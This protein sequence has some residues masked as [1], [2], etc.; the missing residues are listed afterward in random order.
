MVTPKAVQ[1][2]LFH[3]LPHPNVVRAPA[4]DEC[5]GSTWRL[6]LWD[7]IPAFDAWSCAYTAASILI[8][9]QA[10]LLDDDLLVLDRKVRLPTVHVPTILTTYTIL[11]S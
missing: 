8:Q 3:A 10:F 11:S 5:I 1:V 6:A 7:C 9:L 4:V 2:R